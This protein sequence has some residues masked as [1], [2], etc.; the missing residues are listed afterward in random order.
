MDKVSSDLIREQITDMPSAESSLHQC[1]EGSGNASETHFSTIFHDFTKGVIHS[2]HFSLIFHFI[3]SHFYWESFFFGS[4]N[5]RKMDSKTTQKWLKN[6]TV[7]TPIV[8]PTTLFLLSN[9]HNAQQP[10]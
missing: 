8:C 7:S 5:E 6:A 9:S 3:F 2:S 1:A 10:L 4:K